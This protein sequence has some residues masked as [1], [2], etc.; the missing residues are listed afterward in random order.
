[1]ES[2][3]LD[4]KISELEPSARGIMTQ[5]QNAIKSYTGEDARI[6]KKFFRQEIWEYSKNP[7]EDRLSTLKRF[8]AEKLDTQ[9]NEEASEA[10][11]T[12]NE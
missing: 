7:S 4:Q 9:I 6:L 8:S 1:M 10:S 11:D 5:I 2:E 3:A 12:S